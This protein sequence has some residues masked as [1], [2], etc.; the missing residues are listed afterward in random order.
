MRTTASGNRVGNLSIVLLSATATLAFLPMALAAEDSPGW[1]YPVNPPDFKPTPDDGS[2]RRVPDST[3]GY[4]AA[5]VRDLF[6]AP[7]WHREDHPPMPPVVA[8]GR[9][10][11]VNACG[12]C[13]RAEGTGGPENASLAGLP[14]AYIVQQMADYKSGARSTAV[15]GRAPQALMIKTAKAATDEEVREAAAYFSA[16]KPK[17]NIRVVESDN[18]PRTHVHGWFLTKSEPAAEESLGKRIVEVPDDLY[19]FES[20]DTRV[21]FSAYVPRGSVARG[22]KL[23]TDSSHG[24]PCTTCHGSDLRGVNAAPSIAGRSPSYMFRQLHEFKTGVRA[25]P[26]AAPM[27]DSMSRLDPDDMIAIAAYLGTLK[28]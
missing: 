27:K 11:D 18:A 6:A 2:T 26:G 10:P 15:P 7:D 12:V 14:M 9:K 22:Q 17:A 5:Q 28:P 24:P 20:R 1:A 19:R 3:A 13:H 21:T 16:L 25:G 4:T 23:V 8:N